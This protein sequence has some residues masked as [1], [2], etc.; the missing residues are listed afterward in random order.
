MDDF[1]NSKAHLIGN[2]RDVSQSELNLFITE[3]KGINFLFERSV[4]Y[5][6]I[7][8]IFTGFTFI[9]GI[10]FSFYFYLVTIFLVI[11]ALTNQLNIW[12]NRVDIAEHLYEKRRN[13]NKS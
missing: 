7:T 1:I 8:E 4:Q 3:N 6:I 13:I 11:S 10:I 9:L 2:S 5:E 12:E